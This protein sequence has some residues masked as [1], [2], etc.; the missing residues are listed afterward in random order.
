MIGGSGP[1]GILA[2]DGIADGDQ[3]AIFDRFFRAHSH[4]DEKLGV[5]GTGL[6]LAIVADCIKALGGTVR[7]EW[8][9]GQGTTFHLIVPYQDP[10]FAKPLP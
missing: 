7:C 5:D 3:H 9:M 8:S 10:S 2:P 6:G 1:G 4:L